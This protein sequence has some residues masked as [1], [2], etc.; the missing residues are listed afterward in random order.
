MEKAIIFITGMSGTGKSTILNYLSAKGHKTI[1][2]DGNEEFEKPMFHQEER[3]VEWVWAED[4]IQEMISVH[5][6]GVLFLSGTVSNQGKFYPYFN[7]VL[8]LSAPTEIM[9]ERI[10]KR[11]TNDFG[12]S[13]EERK[14][15]VHDLEHYG[16]II[17]S[18]ATQ[19]I[20]TAKSLEST[21][22]EIER[23]GLAYLN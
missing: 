9:L 6:E 20:D 8:Y 11:T 18:S 21:I 15:I 14:K 1:D 13:E 23:I 4:K 10:Q 3:K 17:E 16:S 2:T 19:T 22:D 7:E 12:K 5:T